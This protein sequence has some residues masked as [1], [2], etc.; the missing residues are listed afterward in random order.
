MGTGKFIDTGKGVLIK[1]RFPRK[2]KKAYKKD[3]V[4]RLMQV[5]IPIVR[6]MTEYKNRRCLVD[7]LSS[8]A[9]NPNTYE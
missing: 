4:W 9:F 5:S 6:Q 7:L 8:S 2:L 1:R 3:G